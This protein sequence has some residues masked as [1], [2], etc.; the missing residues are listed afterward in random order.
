MST[1]FSFK[2]LTLKKCSELKNMNLK[3]IQN[4]KNHGFQTVL[5]NL[6]KG[7]QI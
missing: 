1:I 4:T 5:T 7:S 3:N 2:N 6:K